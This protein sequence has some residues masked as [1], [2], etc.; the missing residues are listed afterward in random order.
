MALHD[1][2]HC[3]VTY[4]SIAAVEALMEGKP[5]IVLGQNAASAVAET[6]LAN[7]ESTKMP[8]RDVMEAF[9]A[10]M[11]YCQYDVMELRSGYAW[12][13]ANEISSELSRRNT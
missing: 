8:D 9:F 3:L 1:D 4:N 10:H 11:G 13:M 7:I 5:A 12:G 2:V 6:N